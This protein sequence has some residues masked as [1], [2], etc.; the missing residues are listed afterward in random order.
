VWI[1]CLVFFQTAL[2]AGYLHAHALHRRLSPWAQC[3][4]HV[5]ALMLSLPTLTWLLAP[6]PAVA[7]DADPTL[8]VLRLLTL[9]IGLP[10]VLLASTSPLLQ[11]WLVRQPGAAPPYR[12]YALSNLASLGALLG[13]P[14]LVEPSIPWRPQA[15]GWAAAYAGFALLSAV[16][17]LRAARGSASGLS[18][19]DGIAE[20][21][22]APSWVER[23]LRTGLAACASLLLLA[24]TAHIT[25]HIVPAPLLWVV[26]LAA[27]LLSFV[28]C[29]EW[30]RLY[31]R[32][33]W[34]GLL[35]VALVGMAYLMRQGLNELAALWRVTLFVAGL[36]A[37]C[38]VCH[39]EIARRRPGAASLTTY[40]LLIALGGALGGLFAGVVA[41]L[42]F[43]Q[44]VELPLGLV[45]TGLGG[46]LV[47]LQALWPR[48]G[49]YGRPAAVALLPFA[50]GVY[51]TYVVEGMR[52]S[53]RGYRIVRS[54]Y[55][56]LGVRD[57]GEEGT[58]TAARTLVHGGII[59]GSQ[60]RDDSR[61]RFP[62]T[63]YCETSGVGRALA[64]L[65]TSRGRRVGVVG[66]GAGTLVAYGRR[67][68]VYRVYEINPLVVRLAETEF[69][70]LHES[71]AEFSVLL[72]DA[73]RKL[74]G[75]P[76]QEF[77]QLAVDAFSGDSIPAHLL[78]QEALALYVRHLAP[79]GILAVHVSNRFVDFEPVLA[80]GAL[81]LRRP[82][83]N[84][85]GEGDS[86]RLC[87]NSQWVLIPPT[88]GRTRYPA[89]WQFGST[90]DPTP[91]F[92]PWT[93]ELWS[94]YPVLR[95]GLR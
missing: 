24:V 62:T 78:T 43:A 3:A 64:L 49:R 60:W 50:L 90:L 80:A 4:V 8:G 69:T 41:P 35:P 38:M 55:G 85:L 39:G 74:E 37:C 73:R 14:I 21:T 95:K 84:V 86:A 19:P 29:F 59:H 83:V 89:L 36:F 75:E 22:A 5:G 28:I 13:Y 76:P 61:R 63:Y 70:F 47:S 34:M 51:T 26:P 16:A 66:L 87:Y 65:P 88:D 45:L 48:L 91:G 7:L 81:A 46:V 77:D 9:T 56:Q 94:L 30:P 58:E 71:A 32:P 44:P 17:A 27:Y 54:F 23:G 93:D 79:G 31:W 2:L 10:Y 72:G 92:R 68:D 53:T 67:G 6:G 33:V 42:S 25:Q 40:Y 52:A 20:P 82:A 11:A 18:A 15:I 57:D 1:T 12:L